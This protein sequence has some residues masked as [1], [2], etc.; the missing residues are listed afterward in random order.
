MTN[1]TSGAGVILAAG[2]HRPSVKPEPALLEAGSGVMG[3]RFPVCCIETAVDFDGA[4]MRFVA[5]FSG[6]LG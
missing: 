3:I 2:P 4:A 1:F 6:L 5:D